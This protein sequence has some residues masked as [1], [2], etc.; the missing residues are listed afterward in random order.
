MEA[1]AAVLVPASSPAT[2]NP[3]G[4]YLSG[5]KDE[6]PGRH[7][8]PAGKVVRRGDQGTRRRGELAVLVTSAV[9]SFT[10][11]AAL[12]GPAPGAALLGLLA[13]HEGGHWITGRVT[14]NRTSLP[15][16]L[17][18]DGAYV[19]LTR[20]ARRPEHALAISL[21]GPIAGAI[22]GMVLVI[23][24][25][26]RY[27]Q[28]GATFLGGLGAG[29]CLINLVNLNDVASLDGGHILALTGRRPR[30]LAA[31]GVATAAAVIPFAWS[32]HAY[33]APLTVVVGATV[34]VGRSG[35]ARRASTPLRRP[36]ADARA[37][38]GYLFAIVAALPAV[39]FS[40]GLAGA[41]EFD[42]KVAFLQGVTQRTRSLYDARSSVYDNCAGNSASTCERAFQALWLKAH[43]VADDVRDA[44]LPPSYAAVRARIASACEAVANVAVACERDVA[45]YSMPEYHVDLD[46]LSTP[47][48]SADTAD[49]D[50]AQLVLS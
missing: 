10:L 9:L 15:A 16:F 32:G 30:R 19:V 38:G 12:M 6:P 47:L 34:F 20:P 33:L 45:V 21:A 41:L 37:W 14:G 31:A 23:V 49:Q 1:A 50:A 7:A 35:S 39:S 46:R 17:G 36:S 26:L 28:P 29:G 13:V 42:R 44:E 27:P 43:A 2:L 3:I 25:L 8:A 18:F 40:I 5:W 11:L 24:G 48:R 4:P 22:G